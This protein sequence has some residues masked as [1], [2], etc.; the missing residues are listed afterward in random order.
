ML[1]VAEYLVTE[2]YGGVEQDDF[3]NTCIKMK[4]LLTP[5][6]LLEK[7]HKIEAMAGRERIIRWGPRTLDI[8]ILMYDDEVCEDE[9]LL[10]PHIQ[11]HKREFVLNPLSEIAPYK[12]HPV[13]KKTVVQMRDE[14]N[15]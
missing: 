14:L 15:E 9:D 6:E 4:T 1:K 10:I 13:L 8:D 3:L 12:L 2:P 7:I 11:M 5:R